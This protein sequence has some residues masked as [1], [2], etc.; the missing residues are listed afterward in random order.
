MNKLLERLFNQ[1]GHPSE[2]KNKEVALTVLYCMFLSFALV[3]MV[4]IFSVTQLVQ[5]SQRA[6]KDCPTSSQR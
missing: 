3:G 2:Y 1:L 5:I 6:Q 4:E